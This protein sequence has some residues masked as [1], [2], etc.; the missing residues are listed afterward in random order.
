[1][2]MIDAQTGNA[3]ETVAFIGH[4]A[5]VPQEGSHGQPVP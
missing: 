5:T 4:C 1:M 3:G 2:R